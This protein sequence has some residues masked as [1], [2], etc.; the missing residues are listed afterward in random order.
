MIR[1]T[2]ASQFDGSSYLQVVLRDVRGAYRESV[3][4]TLFLIIGLKHNLYNDPVSRVNK[5]SE[6]TTTKAHIVDIH[7]LYKE[8]FYLFQAR[9]VPQV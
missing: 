5:K 9:L 6:R 4:R 1:N 7:T 8:T 2:L 3:V